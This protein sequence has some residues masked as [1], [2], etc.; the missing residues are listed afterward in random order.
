MFNNLINHLK[1]W[2]KNRAEAYHRTYGAFGGISYVGYRIAYELEFKLSTL[3]DKTFGNVDE[4]NREI[5]ALIDVHYEP[6]VLKPANRVAK[7]IIDKTNQ[8]FLDYLEEVVSRKD[9]LPLVDIP[10]E[11]VITGAEASALQAKFRTVW[12]YENT[13]YWF[14]LMGDEPKGISEKFFIML[15]FFEPY[16]K[17][18]EGIIGLPESHIYSYGEHTFRPNHCIETAELTEYGGCETIYTD[19]SFSWAVYFSHE[20]TVAFAGS[21]VPKVKAL[22]ANEIE[23]W[24]KFE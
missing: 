8:E 17:Q 11:R 15:D 13:A 7:H 3:M 12:G 1:I 5:N 21:I 6:S 19:K 20:E 24:N 14:P 2:C 10:Y 18:F 4:I 16:M 22:L 23:H 9:S